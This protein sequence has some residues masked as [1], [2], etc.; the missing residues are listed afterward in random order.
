[1][2][3]ALVP[4]QRP[5]AE[6]LL[7]G[8]IPAVRTALH[9][10]REKASAEGRPAPNS[11]ALLAIAEGL[12]P[13]VKAAEW[14]DR[15][16]AA[17]K[18]IDDV[19]VRDLRLVVAGSDVARDEESRQL[20]ST[21]R[22][23]LEKRLEGQ[24]DEWIREI[25]Q[26]LEEGR[27]VRALRLSTHPPDPATKFPAELAAEL[28]TAAGEAMTADTPADRWSALLD[29]AAASP[30]RRSVRPSGLPTDPD[31]DLLRAA[32]A[33]SGRIPALA[34]MLG[35]TMPPPPGP[36]GRPGRP[37]QPPRRP[38][39]GGRRPSGKAQPEQ[40]D[41]PEQKGK[42]EQKVQSEQKEQPE[43]MVQSE[44]K[45]QPEKQDRAEEKDEAQPI[46]EEAQ[47]VGDVSPPEPIAEEAQPV[48][49]VTP[50]EPAEPIVDE[51][52]A[53]AAQAEESG[54]TNGST[55]PNSADHDAPAP[56]P[57]PASPGH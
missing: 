22:E 29:A 3:E 40:K 15:A 13:R 48:A 57:T 37:A 34:T 38:R 49:D 14:R 27:V 47:P 32:R 8:G 6:Q 10:E 41:K 46:A 53:A 9:L 25:R 28:A 19:T 35:I 21:L 36:I 5:I 2:L 52:P 26:N 11:E 31:P 33:Q 1:L 24:R 39:S 44:Q 7:R 55:E 23:T 43:R 4:E 51:T 18:I 16:E 54:A 42:P 17:M 30:V 45:E 20:V 12:L 56:A 50:S